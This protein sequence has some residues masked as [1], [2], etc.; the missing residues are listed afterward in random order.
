MARR[1][2]FIGID[3]GDAIRGSAKALQKELAKVD[4]GV[5]W[6]T[7]ESM[8]VTLLFLGDVDDRELHAVCKAVAAAARGEPSFSLRVSGL[9]VF[10]NARRPKVVWAGVTDGADVLRRLHT[11]LE[12]KMLALGGYRSEER[13]Y[14]PH[15]TLGRVNTPEAAVAVAAELPKRTAWQ[16]GRVTVDEVLVYDSELNSDGPVYTVVGRAPLAGQ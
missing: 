10:P 7:P 16:G 12:E 3:I 11:A 14:T 2:T 4:P 15:L 6:V 13:G 5:K 1:R 8:H 9:G